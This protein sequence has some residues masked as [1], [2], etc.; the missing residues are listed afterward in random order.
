MSD[1]TADLDVESTGGVVAPTL[2]GGA[3]L[4]LGKVCIRFVRVSGIHDVDGSH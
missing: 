1:A 4:P 2:P 3:T